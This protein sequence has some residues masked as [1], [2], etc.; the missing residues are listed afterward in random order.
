MNGEQT[1]SLGR[2]A[3][4]EL[5]SAVPRMTNRKAVMVVNSSAIEDK[6]W[7]CRGMP[8]GLF[9]CNEGLL[10]SGFAPTSE[11]NPTWKGFRNRRLPLRTSAIS[12]ARVCLRGIAPRTI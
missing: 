10:Q 3:A 5:G 7:R 4:N 2:A 12:A 6:L 9:L 11:Q 1:V 8:A